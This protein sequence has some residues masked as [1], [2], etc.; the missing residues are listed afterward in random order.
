MD[1][2][3]QKVV[4]KVVALLRLAQDQ[5][6]EN[7][8]KLASTRALELIERNKVTRQ[9]VLFVAN[10][11][12]APRRRVPSPVARQPRRVVFVTSSPGVGWSTSSST[13]TTATTGFGNGFI[14]Y[15]VYRSG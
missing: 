6:N 14:R 3:R 9:E 13:N 4:K 12:S 7:E 2:E 5:S 8:S 11:Q 1:A 15:T 10:A